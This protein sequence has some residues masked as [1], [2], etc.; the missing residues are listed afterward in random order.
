MR[1]VLFGAALLGALGSF[2]VTS[3]SLPANKKQPPPCVS[4]FVARP[5]D[6]EQ[7]LHRS[8]SKLQNQLNCNPEYRE[9][10]TFEIDEN[11]RKQ[12]VDAI[13]QIEKDHAV[14]VL[15]ACESGSR[16]WGFPSADSDYDVRAFDR[17]TG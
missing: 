14:K 12:I 17:L 7:R 3:F 15:Y 5:H 16:A 1:L 4:E 2:L 11:V 8:P 9:S 13:H 6:Q 10:A